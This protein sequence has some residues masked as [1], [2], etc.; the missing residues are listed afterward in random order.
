M[1]ILPVVNSIDWLQSALEFEC[2]M[3]LC[4]HSAYF[5][6]AQAQNTWV[7]GLVLDIVVCDCDVREV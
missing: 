4:K 3:G 5:Y 2:R 1:R 7:L 6:F